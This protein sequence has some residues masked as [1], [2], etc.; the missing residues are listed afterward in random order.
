[1]AEDFAK[2]VAACERG[3]I[4]A[5]AGCGKTYQISEAVSHCKGR[6]LILT[7]T[8]AGVKAIR[9]RM[10]LLRVPS[11]LYRVST[12]DS[13]ALRYAAAFPTISAWTNRRPEKDEWQQLRPAAAK[14]LNAG[15]TGDVLRASYEGVF[16]DEYQDCT[17]EQHEIV[18]RLAAVLPCRVLGDPLQAVFWSINREQSLSWGQVE[19]DFPLVGTLSHPHRWDKGN[20]ALG[21]WLLRF[22]E[23]LIA[24]E[25]IDLRRAPGVTVE[26]GTPDQ[27]SQLKVCLNS[28]SPGG[29]VFAL[30]KFRP[31]CWHLAGY[32]NGSFSTFEDAECEELINFTQ[33]LD[34]IEGKER[35]KAVA[36]F[37]MRWLTRLPKPA[38]DSVVNAVVER[39]VT[40]ARRDDLKDLF[41][42]L[43]GLRDDNDYRK[44][45][46]VLDAFQSL[47]EKPVLKS[48]EIWHGLRRAVA[49]WSPDSGKTLFEVAWNQRNVIRRVGRTPST[50]CLATPLLVKGLE[51]HHSLI[52][53]VSEFPDAESL[54]VCFTRA[55]RSV[56]VLTP[57]FTISARRVAS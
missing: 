56:T 21:Q 47:A 55:S 50:R 20:K 10:I 29:S 6:Q 7:H 57:S 15:F 37:A 23:A 40:R 17:K 19:K 1:M 53:D 25:Q 5:P 32:L 24:G 3:L 43:A 22:R 16:V 38:L 11:E 28:I 42:A 48:H 41:E 35:V 27:P 2:Q 39:R 44:L 12:I 46:A 26:Q 30:R 34:A 52:L 33:K 51:C 8:H 18:M 13:F 31:Q 45:A 36:A 9:D 49:A 4:I 54:Y 14:V